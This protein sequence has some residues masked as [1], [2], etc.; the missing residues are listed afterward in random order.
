MKIQ[1]I[2]GRPRKLRG[3]LT[4]LFSLWICLFFVLPGT[5]RGF[6]QYIV[7]SVLPR[8]AQRG[9]CVEVVLQG[10]YLESPRELVS[11]RGGI[12]AL[13]FGSPEPGEE[14]FMVPSD[15]PQKLTAQLEIAPDCPLGIHLLFLRT[16]RF[17]SDPVLFEVGEFPVVK[18]QE[19]SVGQNDSAQTAQSV[20]LRCTVHGRIH[21]EK[22][23]ADRDCYAVTAAK[24]ERLSFDLEAVRVSTRHYMGENDCQIRVVG[25]DGTVC[26]ECDDSALYIQDPFVSF[27]APEDGRYVVEV[28]QHLG[29]IQPEAAY[30]LLHVGTFPRPEAVY[31]AGGRPGE[32]IQMRWIWGAEGGCRTVQLPRDENG[33]AG[34]TM[35]QWLPVDGGGRAQTGMP[36]RLSPHPNALEAEPNGEASSAGAVSV[37]VA[38]NGVIG[39]PGDVDCWRVHLEA[40]ESV[41][42]RVYARS[43]GTPLDPLVWVR[44]VGSDK[45]EIL[46]D[47]VTMPER[48]YASFAQK[49]RDILDPALNFVAKESGEY[50]VGVE[51]TRGVGGA[52]FVYRMELERHRDT[53]IVYPGRVGR[54]AT[55]DWTTREAVVQV[56]RG[57]GWTTTLALSEGIGTHFGEEEFEI[58]AVGLPPG[59]RLESPRIRI[60]ESG[61]AFPV[62]F[63]A[64]PEAEPRVSFVQLFA[65][66]VRPGVEVES[67]YQRGWMFSN[68]RGGLGWMP[69]WM[70]RLPVAVVEAP[71]FELEIARAKLGMVQAGD[72]EL[73]VN[74]RRREGWD[75][76]VQLKCDCL[77]TGVTQGVPVEVGPGVGTARLTLMASPDAPLK[78]WKIS[79]CGSS[80]DGH[81]LY[82]TGAR[83]VSSP[84]VDLEV[85]KPYVLVDLERSSVRRGA[86][87]QMHA[88]LKPLKPFPAGARATL[89][90]LPHGVKQVEPFPVIQDKDTSCVFQVSATEEA[91]LGPYKQIQVELE[92]TDF[93]GVIR[94]K[95]GAGV[96]RVDPALAAGQ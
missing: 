76:P 44:K 31:P 29:A 84:M 65:R 72:M 96:L 69:V 32:E 66:P 90:G 2:S 14:R 70:D 86:V 39:Q 34:G 85:G 41:D 53:V 80:M 25:P 43:L 57:G 46:V 91:L 63:V 37:P 38:V 8:G 22:D 68:R 94:Q 3:Q 49:S 4:V 95:S 5:A 81:V 75:G 15:R 12:R 45:E 71:C 36:L 89:I 20:P 10:N 27:L 1:P 58:E 9:T 19:R 13:S 48:G 33:G 54:P 6:N 50:V 92:V 77:P 82:G 17:V 51:D 16:D 55:Y 79:V 62:R 24:G 60:Q 21:A 67:R 52:A 23:R 88:K 59:V 73:E 26:A 35:V 11:S 47:D 40:G 61:R 56:P 42:I 30:Y 64:S 18:E 74:V 83:L 78:N 7:E 28:S 93:G 87:D